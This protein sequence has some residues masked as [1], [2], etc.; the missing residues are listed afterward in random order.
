MSDGGQPAGD[1]R[2]RYDTDERRELSEGSYVAALE[3]VPLL[4]EAVRPTSAIDV[5]CG[6]GGWLKA[7][8]DAGVERVQG[9]DGGDVADDVL[10]ID[11]S[12]FQRADLRRPIER[13]GT[14]DLVVSIE[15]GEHLPPE[16]AAGFVHDLCSFGD[17]VLF[18][19]AI[20]GA[21]RVAVGGPQHAGHINEQWPSYWAERFRAE[22]YVPVDLIRPQL[23]DRRD[24]A[25]AVRQHLLVYVREGTEGIGRA[26]LSSPA[27]GPAYLD[28]VHPQWVRAIM[29]EIERPGVRQTL[30]APAAIGRSIRNRLGR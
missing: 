7:L 30:K 29:L 6:T 25:I 13:T 22:G 24:V 19:A 11:P 5:G 12:C 27:A 28:V 21:S 20:P 1:D 18:S 3:V 10:L 15:V 14:F 16:R 4:L 17:V 8:Q 9:I 23:W 2:H 26:L